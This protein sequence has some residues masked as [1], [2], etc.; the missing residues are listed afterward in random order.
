MW[1]KLLGNCLLPV[2]SFLRR[3]A[4]SAMHMRCSCAS[5][6]TGQIFDSCFSPSLIFLAC[7]TN[8]SPRRTSTVS[9]DLSWRGAI[10]WKRIQRTTTKWSKRLKLFV[11]KRF[12]FLSMFYHAH[13]QEE[14]VLLNLE[15]SFVY[16][17]TLFSKTMERTLNSVSPE[18]LRK[19]VE[20]RQ[21]FKSLIKSFEQGDY[22]SFDLVHVFASDISFVLI[23]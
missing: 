11:G 12:S 7:P 15:S 4:T 19:V 3:S 21:M 16:V 9:H 6:A 23:C 5:K 14:A 17:L 22:G 18:E 8:S 10:R 13:S 1:R 20:C 2:L